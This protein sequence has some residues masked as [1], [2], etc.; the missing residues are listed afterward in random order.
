ML[1]VLDTNVL[2]A[3]LSIKSPHHWIIEA[4]LDEHF[5]LCVSHDILLEYEEVLT[6]KYGTSIA[7]NFLKAL[8]EL[9]NVFQVNVWYQWNLL[10]DQDDN[11]FVDA[12]IAGGASFIVSEDRHFRKLDEVKFPEVTLMRLADFKKWYE[13]K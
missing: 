1:F 2:V 5:E 4:L 11:K 6:R 8:Q 7:D 10:T 3:A 13:Y 9:P 12:A